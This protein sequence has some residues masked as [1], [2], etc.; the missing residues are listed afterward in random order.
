MAMRPERCFRAKST[1]ALH[2]GDARHVVRSL[3]A[4]RDDDVP[5]RRVLALLLPRPRG[6]ARRLV[7]PLASSSPRARLHPSPHHPVRRALAR[8][9]LDHF[10]FSSDATYRQRYF[11]CRRY[12]H[13]TDPVLFFYTGNEANV[14]LYLNATGI[15]W[16]SAERF[17]AALAR[18]ASL[19][20]RVPPVEL[21]PRLRRPAPRPARAPHLR[22]GHGGLRHPH[23]RRP[24]RTPRPGR[25]RRRLRRILRRHARHP[26][27]TRDPHLADAAVP[28]PRPYGPSRAKIRPSTPARS[29]WASPMTPQSRAALRRRA[30]PTS[31]KPS[32][33]ASSSGRRRRD[34]RVFSPR[35]L[36]RVPDGDANRRGEKTNRRQG[37]TRA[38]S[39]RYQ[40]SRLGLRLRL[41]LRPGYSPTR[42]LRPAVASAMEWLQSAFDYLAMGNFPYPSGYILNGD[43]TLPAYPFRVACGGDVSDPNLERRGGDALVAALVDAAGRFTITRTTSRAS[44]TTRGSTRTRTRTGNCGIGSFARRCTC[45]ARG[46]A[47]TTCSGRSRERDGGGGGM[48]GAMGGATETAVGGHRVRGPTI[49]SGV[50]R[51]V[52]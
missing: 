8:R 9:P 16:E 17:G 35:R 20:R 41:R 32:P 24:P 15:M 46:T 14:E 18:R 25:P 42:A 52:E 28:D 34:P 30:R 45:P 43:G 3:R 1:S 6:L 37:R 31:A 27:A 13:P 5:P 12:A 38:T 19:L 51:R 36:A 48:R 7:T 49:A 11:L 2:D 4:R 44:T 22:T 39:R 23:P 26:D 10:S 29:P 21:R 47:S 50:Q 33:R 40:T